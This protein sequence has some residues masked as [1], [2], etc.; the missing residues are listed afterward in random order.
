MTQPFYQELKNCRRIGLFDSGLGGLT[1][2]DKLKKLSSS[3]SANGSSTRFKEFIYLGDTARCPYGNRPASEIV[4]FITEIVGWLESQNVDGI[5]VACNTSASV[6]L[7]TT[8]RLSTV[9]IFD[10]ITPTAN[11]VGMLG[12]KVAVMATAATVRAK[13]FSKAIR[14]VNPDM[15]VVEI[16]CPDLVPIIEQ[17]K[18]YEQA[19][20]AV[21]EKYAKLLDEA[22][23]EVL[24]W[25][26]T[27]FPFLTE[28][29]TKLL[30]RE[31]VMVDPADILCGF[32]SADRENTAAASD[33]SSNCAIYVTGDPFDFART[34]KICLGYSLDTVAGIKVE[35]V[36]GPIVSGAVQLEK[37]EATES[38]PVVPAV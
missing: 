11:Y 38:S 12:R 3:P 32:Q 35:E 37:T 26:C 6:G 28:P 19:T 7:H 17:G 13:A 25:G 18:I 20:T 27:H 5:V 4:T 30:K 29:F 14:L 8:H 24:V 16:A 22:K 36:I 31:I 1:V 9:P 21:L 33:A 23:A 34:A 15:D 10:L 2:L